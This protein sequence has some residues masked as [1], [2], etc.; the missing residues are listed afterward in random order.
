MAWTFVLVGLKPIGVTRY[1]W[2][3]R[4]VALWKASRRS[5][6]HRKLDTLAKDATVRVKSK[7]GS[8]RWIQDSFANSFFQRLGWRLC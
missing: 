1:D 8:D 7:Q 4:R 2:A 5:R 6:M 3:E